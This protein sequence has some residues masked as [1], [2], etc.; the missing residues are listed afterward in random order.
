MCV[1]VFHGLI[2][3]IEFFFS[4]VFLQAFVPLSFASQEVRE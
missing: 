2:A 4:F 1:V 3:P